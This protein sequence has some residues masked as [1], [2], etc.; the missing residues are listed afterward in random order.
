MHTPVP[1]GPT[2]L[3]AIGRQKALRYQT[4]MKK[5]EEARNETKQTETKTPSSKENS[6]LSH[7]N[8]NDRASSARCSSVRPVSS[9]IMACKYV[10]HQRRY[11]ALERLMKRISTKL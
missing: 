3:P 9:S 11:E 6:V 2:Y 8:L 7:G 4:D 1:L 10:N 5:K